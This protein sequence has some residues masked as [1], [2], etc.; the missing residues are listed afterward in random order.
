MAAPSAHDRLCVLLA[1]RGDGGERTPLFSLTPVERTA[2]AFARAGVRRFALTGDAEAVAAAEAAIRKGPCARLRVRTTASL[3]AAAGDEPFFLARTD[4]HYDRQLVLR[5]VAEN[6]AAMGS[7]VAVDFRGET[8]ARATELPRVAVW[9][10]DDATPRVQSV[11]RGL[12]VSDGVLIGLAVATPAWAR[13]ADARRDAEDDDAPLYATPDPGA[14]RAFQGAVQSLLAREPI[15]TWAVAERW[16]SVRRSEDVPRARREVLAGAVR[17]GD[18][19]VARYLNRPISLRITER[20]ITRPVKP[21]QVSVTTFVM[22]LLA[23][24]SFAVGHATTGGLLA[25]C[26]S[27]LDG[28]DGEL[29]R[30]RYQDS[31]FGGLYDA[32]LDRVGEAAVIGGMTLYAW[33]AGAGASAVALGFAA[34]AGNSLSMLVKEKY[35]TQFQRPWLAE[36]EGRW[37]WALLGRDGRLFLALLAGV[38]G[39]IELVLAYLAVGTHVQAGVRLAQIRSE[40]A[41]A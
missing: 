41:R 27:V 17:V 11:G 40:A 21:W 16:Q 8:P 4:C 12:A 20:L 2:L 23:G 33:L 5:F 30:V 24:L 39:Q 19:V 31:A 3:A 28:V 18:G 9:S 13:A 6:A 29:A 10:R 25:Q 26:A 38:T 34:L 15:A 36:R 7:V 37:R 14:A 32:L 1:V 22:T 35:G